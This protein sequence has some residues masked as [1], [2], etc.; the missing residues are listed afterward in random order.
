ML[1]DADRQP[2]LLVLCVVTGLGALGAFVYYLGL[3]SSS[4]LAAR[5]VGASGVLAI[6]SGLLNLAMFLRAQRLREA[7]TLR[8]AVIAEI[9]CQLI[10][11][12]VALVGVAFK[13]DL[14]MV[15]GSVA[16]VLVFL[17]GVGLHR[18]HAAT[19]TGHR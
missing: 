9:P 6:A 8:K 12:G 13:L 18:R 4:P 15:L 19:R 7:P 17:L 5:L 14:V 16:A 1:R 10:L 11:W 2:I 3:E